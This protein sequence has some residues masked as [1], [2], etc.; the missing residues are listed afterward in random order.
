MKHLK[1]IETGQVLYWHDVHK[2]L[3]NLGPEMLKS[4]GMEVVN[5]FPQK[6]GERA[7]LSNGM[8]VCIDLDGSRVVAVNRLAIAEYGKRGLTVYR[9]AN[10]YAY[11]IPPQIAS[12]LLGAVK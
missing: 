4:I 7:E 11:T 1:S 3:T 12:W 6:P 5:E 2:L 10:T 8:E 9:P